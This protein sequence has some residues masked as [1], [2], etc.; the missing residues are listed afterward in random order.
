[1][2]NSKNPELNYQLNFTDGKLETTY[3]PI[4][5]PVVSPIVEHVKPTEP[6]TQSLNSVIANL[7]TPSSAGQDKTTLEN[8][9]K[10]NKPILTVATTNTTEVNKIAKQLGQ[11][12]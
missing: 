10:E 8:E 4:V 9:K 11:C 3:S 1:M 2:D 6:V 12:K 7:P 5:D